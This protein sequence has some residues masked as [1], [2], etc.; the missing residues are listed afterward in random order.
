MV[1]QSGKAEKDS[2]SASLKTERDT[3]KS[4]K[5]V[6]QIL[7]FF[8]HNRRSASVGEIVD[9]LD[10]PQSSTSVLLKSL[11]KL[12]YLDYDRQ[13]H[14][15]LPTMRVAFLGEWIH[16]QLFSDNSLSRITEQLH[17]KTGATVLIGM[18]NDIYVHYIH[19]IQEPQP[20]VPLY[21]KPG[22][23]RPLHKAALGKVL[24]SQKTDVDA[25]A[26]VRRINGEEPDPDQRVNTTALLAELDQIR[27]QGYAYTE[28]TVRAGNGVVAMELPTPSSQPPMAI[29]LGASIEV[30]KA[31]KN[32]FIDLLDE[33]VRPFRARL[34]WKG[35]PKKGA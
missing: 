16:D 34:S 4:A 8:A 32:E 17:E 19:L 10:F 20:T 2:E 6:L 1:N 18:Q 3:V 35:P 21:I 33:T 23:L 12:G 31:N 27:R 25:L 22:S 13:R 26:I 14:V 11:T 7:E 28:S 9:E 5:R 15:Y 24:L 30:L 29:G